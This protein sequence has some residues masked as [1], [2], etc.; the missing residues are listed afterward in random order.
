MIEGRIPIRILGKIVATRLRSER[1]ACPRESR[2]CAV[3]NQC[4]GS[5]GG[6]Q[7]SKRAPT[8]GRSK[9]C[10]EHLSSSPYRIDQRSATLSGSVLVV[11]AWPRRVD[12]ARRPSSTPVAIVSPVVAAAVER[13]ATRLSAR[14]R[15]WLRSTPRASTRTGGWLARD[16][17]LAVRS[18]RRHHHPH[19][20]Q[21][22]GDRRGALGDRADR[23][24]AAP[25]RAH[26]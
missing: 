23:D 25:F 15:S 8:P 9:N 6:R 4:R 24:R 20:V 1:R 2:S 5:D 18:E 11:K 26:H 3:A 16:D 13:K 12:R 21:P 10:P 19:P 7:S 17:Q 22:T 14:A